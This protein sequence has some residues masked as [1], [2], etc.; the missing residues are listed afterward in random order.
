MQNQWQKQK[1]MQKQKV[2]AKPVQ[3]PQRTITAGAA[4]VITGASPTQGCST[5]RAM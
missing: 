1:K 4:A 2:T 3:V 5:Q